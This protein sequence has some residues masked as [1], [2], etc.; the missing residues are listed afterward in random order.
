M[1]HDLRH[2]SP[3]CR[4]AARLLSR[5]MES[6]LPSLQRWGLKVH[7]LLCWK[8]RCYESQLGTVRRALRAS[9]AVPGG[10][11]QCELPPE[12]REQMHAAILRAW[13]PPS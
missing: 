3:T 13:S 1:K 7:L 9:D 6:A 11:P 8:C 10:I 2:L 4:D 5:S 12:A